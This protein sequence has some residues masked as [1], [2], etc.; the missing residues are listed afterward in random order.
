MN[1]MK[2]LNQLQLEHLIT[3]EFEHKLIFLKNIKGLL[4]CFVQLFFS[5]EEAGGHTTTT[6]VGLQQQHRCKELV[7]RRDLLF[8]QSREAVAA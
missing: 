1:F 7:G 5:K 8:F 4:L 2:M 6:T 3:I